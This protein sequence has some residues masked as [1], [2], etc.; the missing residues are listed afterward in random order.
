MKLG[1]QSSIALWF[2][3]GHE[4]GASDRTGEL[5]H[6]LGVSLK[7]HQFPDHTMGLEWSAPSDAPRSESSV[8]NERPQTPDAAQ[9]TVRTTFADDWHFA[10]L[11]RDGENVRVHLDGS[12]KPVLTGKAGKAANEVLF[13]QGLEGRL[14]EITIWDRVIEPSLIAKLWNV[15]KVGEENAKRAVS[16]TERKKRGA[17]VSAASE[18]CTTLKVT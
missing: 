3:L 1:T 6:A 16:R 8:R 7:A 14:D 5:I 2:W 17:A 12:E 9:R 13:G 18:D 15:S 11:I 10:V 4:S